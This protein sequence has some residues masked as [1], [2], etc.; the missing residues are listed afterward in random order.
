VAVDAAAVRAALCSFPLGLSV[1]FGPQKPGEFGDVDPRAVVALVKTAS[2]MAD[3]VVID[4]L[5]VASGMTQAAVRQCHLVA[6][7]LE[8]D[9][10]SVYAANL[11]LDVLRA[12]GI[13]QLATGALVVNRVMAQNPLPMNEITSQ[14]DCTIF[15][16]IPPAIDLCARAS[17][18]GSPIVFLEPESAY[19]GVLKDTVERFFDQPSLRALRQPS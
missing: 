11:F 13:S 5:S 3:R 8:C 1:L 4:L 9:A 19:A 14:L 16:V 15:G 17:Q 10:A 12:W 7:V 2:Q 6:M 18:T